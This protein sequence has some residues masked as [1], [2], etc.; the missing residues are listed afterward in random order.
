MSIEFNWF[1]PT[2]GDGRHLA[3]GGLPK[4]QVFSDGNRAPGID[5]LGQI[6]RVAE[7]A[8]FHGILVPVAAGF[9]DPWLV[10]AA[11]ARETSRLKFLL[12]LRPGLELP[13]YT[14]QKLATLQDISN[15]R[16]ALHIVTGSSPYEQRSLGDFLGHDSRY[17]RT[18]EF[19]QIMQHV[20]RG[21]GIEGS[22]Q[23]YQHSFNDGLRVP[24][25]QTPDIYFGGASP[26]AEGVAAQHSDVYVMWG[27]TPRMIRERI[28]RMREFAAARKRRLRFGLRLHVIARATEAQAWEQAD[29]LLN[30]IPRDA[31][32][33]AQRHMA[34]YDSVGQARQMD[35]HGGKRSGVREL[36][37]APNLW[38]GI[39]LV[40]GGAGT[41]FV[42][43]YAQVA[44]RIAEYHA[45][46]IDAFI[47]SGYPNLEEAIRV[48][49][50]VLPRA[51]QALK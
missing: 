47:F 36:E 41:A 11:L 27:E 23:Y 26:I 30:E 6:T 38:A 39:G 10:T 9:E 35:F 22:Q 14:A 40:R 43:S 13:A 42:G 1:L 19:L 50:E 29:K 49:A 44:E 33:S 4:V 15:Q 20:W 2:S 48:G 25:Q 28:A 8:G 21:S 16:L 18:A 24:L 46:G 5:Y 12:T 34:T 17:E 45:F 31:I 3:S 7:S 32:D 37:I 51:G